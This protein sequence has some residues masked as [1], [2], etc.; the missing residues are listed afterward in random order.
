VGAENQALS[1]GNFEERNLFT[2]QQRPKNADD[3]GENKQRI[4]IGKFGSPSKP[5]TLFGGDGTSNMKAQSKNLSHQKQGS[6]AHTYRQ[7]DRPTQQ[8]QPQHFL[9]QKFHNIPATN[10]KSAKFLQDRTNPGSNEKNDKNNNSALFP[11]QRNIHQSN[12]RFSII[13]GAGSTNPPHG[14]SVVGGAGIAMVGSGGR[15]ID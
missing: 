2:P 13:E 6:I 3:T 10:H 11:A 8:Q 1:S 7:P 12:Q 5:K 9:G 4:S 14:T 15:R